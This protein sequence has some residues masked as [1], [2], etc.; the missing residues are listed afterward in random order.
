MAMA[1][2]E[3]TASNKRITVASWLLVLGAVTNAAFLLEGYAGARLDRSV[4]FVSELGARA[5]PAALFFRM[6]DLVAGGLLLAGSA[7]AY[8][9]L[10]RNLAL[11][12]GMIAA[13]VFAGVTALDAFLPLD[14]P[15]TADPVC[16]AAEDAGRVSAT[17]AAHNITGVIL[18]AAAPAAVLLIAL[19]VWQLRRRRQL[20]REWD[21]VWQVLVLTGVLYAWLSIAIA[22]MY[23]THA[24]GLGTIQRV[25]IILYGVSMLCIATA[26]RKYRVEPRDGA[27]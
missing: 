8:P 17:H 6:S 22:V 16:R 2:S 5:E 24:D 18:G 12:L 13:M 1:D 15:P 7:L 14:C 26:L 19:G 21:V 4:S 20:P 27:A 3:A 11:R 10:P 25:Q 23:L 9:L